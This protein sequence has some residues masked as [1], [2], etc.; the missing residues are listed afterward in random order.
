VSVPFEGI[1][2][3]LRLASRAG[4]KV[5]SREARALASLTLSTARKDR[6]VP[7]AKL[8]KQHVAE[9]AQGLGQSKK[10]RERI[11]QALG[12]SSLDAWMVQENLKR[13]AG[14]QESGRE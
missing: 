12:I 8:S 7:W 9:A 11:A 6:K 4:F 14:E 5:W 13:A 3:A 2:I 10:A 1:W